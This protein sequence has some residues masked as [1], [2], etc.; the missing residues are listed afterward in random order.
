MKREF[1]YCTQKFLPLH[2]ILRKTSKPPPPI[3]YVLHIHLNV[4]LAAI[5]VSW[6]VRLISAKQDV[7][8]T[9]DEGNAK[10]G[11]QESLKV[12]K[13]TQI[14]PKTREECNKINDIEQTSSQY[15]VCKLNNLISKNSNSLCILITEEKEHSQK[16]GTW[17]GM[18]NPY[19]LQWIQFVSHVD[20]S[21]YSFPTKIS[22]SF[23]ARCI[24]CPSL[25]QSFYTNSWTGF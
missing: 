12:I 23:Y 2:H 13:I 3:L 9:R 25:M 24:P 14:L 19:Y 7:D 5:T 11:S 21:L 1:Y 16:R 17:L 20:S 15:V 18:F 4:I 10:Q 22:Y 6:T 8:N